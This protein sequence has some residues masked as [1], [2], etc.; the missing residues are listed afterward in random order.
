M[1]GM[2]ILGFIACWPPNSLSV[3]SLHPAAARNRLKR[4]ENGR[5]SDLLD[6]PGIHFQ[7]QSANRLSVAAY[8]YGVSA[9]PQG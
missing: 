1:A 7:H 8:F 9:G 3:A 2:A 5:C 4:A 6:H